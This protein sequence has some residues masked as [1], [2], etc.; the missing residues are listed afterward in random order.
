[1]VNTEKQSNRGKRR[2]ELIWPRMVMKKWLSIKSTTGDAFSSD[3]LSSDEHDDRDLDVENEVRCIGRG[4]QSFAPKL[5]ALQDFYTPISVNSEKNV[6]KRADSRRRRYSDTSQRKSIHTEQLR[7]AVCTWNVAGR[8]PPPNLDIDDWV[9]MG[10]PADIYVIGFQEV[11]PLHAGT[12]F[13]AEDSGPARKW[14]GLIRKTLN[15]PIQSKKSCSSQSSSGKV[16]SEDLATDDGSSVTCLL[17]FSST[18]LD[19][20]TV[21]V[22]KQFHYVRIVSKQMVGIHISIWVRRKF[23]CHI[24]NLKVSCVGLGIMG[25]L[26]NKG[27]ISVSMMIRETSFCF[28]CTHLSSGEKEGAQLRRN[29]DV[30]EILERTY[31]PST[32]LIDKDIPNTICE[33]DRIIWLGD[34]NYRLNTK[35]TDAR[36]LIAREDWT[37]LIQKDQL[38]QEMHGGIFNG[39]QEGRIT[40]P[41]TYKYAVNSTRYSGEDGKQEE[42]R[43]TPA[44]CD[45]ILWHGKGLKQLSYRREELNLSDHRPVMAVFIADAEV[46]CACKFNKAMHFKTVMVEVEEVLC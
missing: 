17:P 19:E 5:Y 32:N 10:E 46:A 9:D 13:G 45:R 25:C 43:R 44:W 37:T 8:V 4:G 21:P 23:R 41:P 11:V 28:V 39:W 15:K 33:H 26:G 22:K 24:H 3:E 16:T 29:A 31:F 42:K 38:R 2:G 6:R 14:Q 12:V 40:F 7:I 1:M 30:A 20:R 27:S 18:L 34:L 35:D 36:F